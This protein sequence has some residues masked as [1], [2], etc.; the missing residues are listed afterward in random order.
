MDE[1]HNLEM[2]EQY[3]QTVATKIYN[4][5]VNLFEERV[6]DEDL[7]QILLSQLQNYYEIQPKDSNYLRSLQFMFE[8]WNNTLP[9][10][11]PASPVKNVV[12]FHTPHKDYSKGL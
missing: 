10:K 11:K 12:F 3:I 2:S 7:K 1:I 6:V 8:N 5:C 4:S 9:Q